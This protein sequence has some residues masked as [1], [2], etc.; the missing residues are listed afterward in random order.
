VIPLVPF[1]LASVILA[2]IP[3]GEGAPQPANAFAGFETHRLANGLKVWFKQLPDDPVVSISVA[4]PF[5]ADQDPP[6]K[7][8]LAHFTEH[9]LF[10]DQP[11]LSEEEIRR[12][13]EERGGVYN[14]SVTVDRTFYFVR[15]GKEHAS[16]A[17]D[18]LFRIIA[19]HALTPE[20]VELQREPVALEVG[21][22]PRQF[23]D[24]VWAYYLNPPFLR[25]PGF[26]ENEFGIDTRSRRDYYPYRSLNSI[27][28]EDLRAFY[29][30]YYVPSL[31]TL[32]L[33][34]DLQREAIFQKIDETFAGLAPREQ[35]APA[36]PLIDPERYRESF[37][38]DYRSN[39]FFNDRFKFYAPTAED[40]VMLIFLSQFLGKRL[41][42]EL[43]F[44]E[45]KATY[46]IRVGIAKRGQAT[47]L[48]I[49]G[50]IKPSEFEYARGVVERE[51]E[52]LRSGS[53]SDEQFEADR[54]AV[55]RQ[56]LVTNTASEDLERWVSGY[57][58]DPR[59]YRDF[60]DLADAYQGYRKVEVERFV[61]Q[62][63]MPERQVHLVIYKNPLTQGVL[64]IFVIVLVWSTLFIASRWL[65][66]RV[67]MTRIRYVAR[68]HIPRPYLMVLALSYFALIAVAAR[69]LTYG[70]EV[71]AVRWLIPIESFV[72]QWSVYAITLAAIV[73]L[74]VLALA[75]IPRKLLV[76]DDHVRIKYLSFRSLPIPAD[77]VVEVSLRRFKEVWLTKRLWRCSPLALGLLAPAVYMKRR[78]GRAYFFDVRD[79]AEL[80]AVLKENEMPA[81]VGAATN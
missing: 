55:T 76:F 71:L 60:P 31:M 17:L 22:R 15:I 3:G 1:F 79:R 27:D 50:G 33:A 6:G 28:S 46:G 19:P 35:P 61:G 62:H 29:D 40:E 59:V 51:L 73:F 48:G 13:I 16:F 56:L 45:R 65:L 41:N 68:F 63:F 52:A 14:A 11:G 70:F 72:L 2:Q 67:D 9:M 12:Q 24:W 57:F 7:E 74:L 32:T 20:V 21:A 49:S 44:G 37:F 77:E 34:G 25:L 23:F 39:V 42:D 5:G 54:A 69:L 8:Q 80:L 53:L 64:A 81:S 4:L 78:D 47:Y 26:W 58:Y 38:W 66:R 18:W 30:A 10:S 75:A 43:R 36:E